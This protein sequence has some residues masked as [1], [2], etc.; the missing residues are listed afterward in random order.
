MSTPEVMPPESVEVASDPLE[1]QAVATPQTRGR[2]SL[3]RWIDLGSTI[4][5]A[6]AT[7]LSAWCAYQSARWG[8]VQANLYSEAGAARTAAVQQANRANVAQSVD[9]GMFLQYVAAI[10]ENN[11]ELAD[12]LFARFRPPM[13]VAMEAWLATTPLGN[14][15][16]PPSP[17]AMPDYVLAEAEEAER[18]NAVAEEK[19]QQARDANQTGDNYVL[20]TV[21]LASVLFF[22]AIAGQFGSRGS[23]LVFL[24]VG[25][26]VLLAVA[27]TLATYP[28]E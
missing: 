8:G 20:L 6:L 10:T 21:I 2:E 17:F 16:A 5:L 4:M 1:S 18:L 15:E 11:S 9:V 7:V 27:G 13:K 14:P 28:I 26:L 25:V 22:G 12:F 3:A 19:G 24:V 23:R